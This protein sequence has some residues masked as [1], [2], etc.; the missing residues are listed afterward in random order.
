ML[1]DPG[2]R[3][4][5][6]DFGFL[7]PPS[8]AREHLAQRGPV[9]PVRQR[10]VD[11]APGQ[12]PAAWPPIPDAVL[13]TF[14][15]D[16][17][18]VELAAG[19]RLYRVVG[20]GSYPNGSFWTLTRPRDEHRMRRDLALL[21]DWNGDH[22]LVVLDLT[23][24]VTAWRGVVGPQRSSDRRGHLPGGG[25]QLWLPAGVLGPLDGRWTLERL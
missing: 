11:F 8:S 22:G 10:V 16:V 1:A 9:P 14:S 4:S 24:P 21:N 17:T 13:L 6:H 25:E 20:D 5:R 7:R 19:Q 2:R 23:R 3:L 18:P 12:D 15:G